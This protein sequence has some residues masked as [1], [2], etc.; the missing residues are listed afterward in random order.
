MLVCAA[1]AFASVPSYPGRADI[2]VAGIVTL[3][4]GTSAFLTHT[5]L[6]D[7]RLIWGLRPVTRSISLVEVE[8]VVE[9]MVP[10]QRYPAPGIVLTLRDGRVERVSTSALLGRQRRSRWIAS[11]D[12]A[13]R[14]CAHES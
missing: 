8:D 10:G 5:E 7:C 2:P 13:R 12:E 4:L 6:R 14:R 1:I 9:G 3:V 11:I